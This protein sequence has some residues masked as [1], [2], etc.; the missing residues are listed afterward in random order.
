MVDSERMGVLRVVG[1]DFG[2]SA[3][4]RKIMYGGYDSLVETAGAEGEWRSAG[5]Q[6]LGMR[7]GDCGCPSLQLWRIAGF[8]LLESS[9]VPVNRRSL[10]RACG[11]I[12]IV[13]RV[14]GCPGTRVVELT[15]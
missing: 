11:Q 5:R 10:E 14:N 2:K 7:R 9:L 15:L 12:L 8:S 3:C 6:G 13:S 1:C 4:A